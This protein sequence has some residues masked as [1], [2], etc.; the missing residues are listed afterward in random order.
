MIVTKVSLN[1]LLQTMKPWSN[2]EAAFVEFSML[3]YYH[4][5]FMHLFHNYLCS[6]HTLLFKPPIFLMP[7]YF[8]VYSLL[9]SIFLLLKIFYLYLN[10]F[11]KVHAIHGISPS[12]DSLYVILYKHV[13]SLWSIHIVDIT[14]TKFYSILLWYF[15]KFHHQII[16]HFTSS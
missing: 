11:F 15:S 16:M 1:K 7:L 9:Y 10:L 2:G 4:N 13:S 6:Y 8:V 12:L 5:T 14:I 3:F